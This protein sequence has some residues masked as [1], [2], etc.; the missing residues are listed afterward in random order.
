MLIIELCDRSSLHYTAAPGSFWRL[1]VDQS[2]NYSPAMA[3]GNAIGYYWPSKLGLSIVKAGE[4]GLI[5]F[6]PGRVNG[7]AWIMNRLP[8]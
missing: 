3:D 6:Q 5:Y 7:R 4:P 8:H 2:V 1:E